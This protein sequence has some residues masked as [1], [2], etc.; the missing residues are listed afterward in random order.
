MGVFF[1]IMKTK[2]ARGAIVLCLAIVSLYAYDAYRQQANERNT[3]MSAIE[4]ADSI[5]CYIPIAEKT[6]QHTFNDAQS[7]SRLR[8][9]IRLERGTR[10]R[11]CYVLT[12]GGMS[13][14][15]NIEKPDQLRIRVSPF[16]IYT[17]RTPSDSRMECF[18]WYADE[19]RVH[20]LATEC[21]FV[22]PLLNDVFGPAKP[23][24]ATEPTPATGE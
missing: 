7:L 17:Y 18:E 22:W 3:I 16:G 5:T 24:Q 19:N 23:K 6:H 21:G 13:I 4:H 10:N 14:E 12:D 1:R 8:A 11:E 15:L 2:V 20:D 9:L